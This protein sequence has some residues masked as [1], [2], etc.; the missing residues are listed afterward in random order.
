[1]RMLKHLLRLLMVAS[2]AMQPLAAQDEN[3]VVKDENLAAKEDNRAPKKS[4]AKKVQAKPTVI[5]TA[6]WTVLVYIAADNSLASYASYNINDMMAGMAGT[7]GINLLVQ[8]DQ[9]RNYKT[10]RYKIT[11]GKKTDVGS[12][13]SEMGYDPANEL[14]AAMQWVKS[15]FPA[16]HYALGLWNHGSGIED[17]EPGVAR[18]IP[19]PITKRG[20]LQFLPTLST[21][22]QRGILYD[23]SQSTCLTNQGLT[24]ALAKIKQT[25]GQ[26]VDLV[27]MDACLMA[28]GEVAYQIKDS[29]NLLVA[30]QQTI[31]GQGYPY[32]KF[33][34]PLSLNPAGTTALQLA[35]NMV[36]AYQQFY[37]TQQ[38]TADFTLA[39]IDVT[40]IGLIKQNIDRFIAAVAACDQIDATTTRNIIVGAR[41]ASTSF[42]M[43]EYIDL[44]SFY[45]AILGQMKK[46]SPKSHAVLN[47]KNSNANKV[48]TAN[49]DYQNALNNLN[50]VIQDGFNK[51][52]TVVLQK[53]AGPVYAGVK[54]LSIY[55]PNTGEFDQSYPLTLFAQ[56]T[57]WLDFV[58]YYQ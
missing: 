26:N 13:Y 32:S 38:P 5:T 18:N 49:P 53:A 34:K 40:S 4:A 17:F 52:A 16:K 30:S 44:Y 37:T 12:I 36:S 8:W 20:W 2:I 51:I 48:V 22:A 3:L 45:A 24:T 50:A 54:G 43:P 9:P 10:W 56:D 42:D 28:M 47:Q 31:P 55:Y 19:N 33:I 27:F 14:V 1:M 41:N 11:P 58:Q 7:Q 39:A 21:P 25:I 6:E 29:V 57:A 46:S 23:D 35:Q 15:K